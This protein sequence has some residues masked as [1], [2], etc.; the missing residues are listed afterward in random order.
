VLD[1]GRSLQWKLS[2]K[3][4]F[5]YYATLKGLEIER[6]KNNIE[7]YVK[8]F[9]IEE[10]LNQ[11]VEELSL[12]QKQITSIVCS[13]ISEA[14]YLFLD[15]PTNGLDLKMKNSLMNTLKTIR[16]KND[17]T[18]IIATHDLE[19]LLHVADECTVI[20]SGRILKVVNLKKEDYRGSYEYYRE[21][22]GYNSEEGGDDEQCLK[23]I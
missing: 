2:V 21:S 20:D 3:D 12:G 17:C 22:F 1:G 5:I 6:I 19:F 23:A 8:H 16:N 7:E 13:L 15:E 14:E 10:L 4:N 18:I 9:H 11:K